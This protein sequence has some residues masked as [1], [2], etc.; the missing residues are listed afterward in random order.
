MCTV[1]EELPFSLDERAAV[2]FDRFRRRRGRSP[3]EL[4]SEVDGESPVALDPVREGVVALGVDRGA[5]T[6]GALTQCCLALSCELAHVYDLVAPV[7]AVVV[8]SEE[9]D[10]HG[11]V[12]VVTEHL[13]EL[14]EFV[15]ERA[16]HAGRGVVEEL[17]LVP[18][19]LHRL[20]PLVQ[21]IVCGVGANPS[22]RRTPPAVGGLDPALEC[23]EPARDLPLL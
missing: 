6:K 22:H 17:H 4:G 20:A 5:R 16:Q 14:I 21:A 23:A 8:C 18:Q 10:Q 7:A 1:D 9:F 13:G 12:V 19:V 11:E 3:F 2:C 15:D